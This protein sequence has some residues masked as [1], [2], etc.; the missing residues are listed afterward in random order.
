MLD[1]YLF[2]T[3]VLNYQ[4][5]K[6]DLQRI[7]KTTPFINLYNWKEVNFP[8]HNK[9]GKKFELSNKSIALVCILLISY[10]Y[11]IILKK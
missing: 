4:N 5:I 1:L 2:T 7:S 6:N 8:S 11:L 3:V 10:M 9:Y